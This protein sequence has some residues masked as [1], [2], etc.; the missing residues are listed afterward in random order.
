[1][2]STDLVA[3]NSTMTSGPG[4][5]PTPSAP[6]VAYRYQEVVLDAGSPTAATG[7]AAALT[8]RLDACRNV[9]AAQFKF[10]G[11]PGSPY[12]PT[13]VTVAGGGTAVLATWPKLAGSNASNDEYVGFTVA[14]RYLVTL[15]LPVQETDQK[16][17]TVTIAT[18]LQQLLARAGSAP[19]ATPTSAA[20]DGGQALRLTAA[21]LPERVFSGDQPLT[22]T[23]MV[24]AG[25]GPCLTGHLP[26]GLTT[27]ASTG[28][29]PV[30]VG[31]R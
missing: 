15:S 8:A 24:V 17:L 7:A 22:W 26:A 2:A 30:T 29:R 19:S 31:R 11:E 5:L 23:P 25:L 4:P 10:P 28:F 9:D 18:S 21:D 1:M 27:V 16:N 13:Q 12:L 3:L 20:A 6:P 14:G